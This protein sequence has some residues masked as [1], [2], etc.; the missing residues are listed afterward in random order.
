M[1]QLQV[2]EFILRSKSLEL[3]LDSAREELAAT[4]TALDLAHKNH[5]EQV[6]KVASFYQ[7]DVVAKARI[8]MLNACFIR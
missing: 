6:A 5:N 1:F 3:E 4:R 2:N 7:K 8:M